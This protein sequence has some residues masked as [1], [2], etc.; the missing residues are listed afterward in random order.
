[1]A[2][3]A[4]NYSIRFLCIRQFQNRITDSVYTVIKQKIEDAG[5]QDEFDIGV[6]SIRHKTTGSDF[7]FYGMARNISDIK[8][9]E[10][11]DICW[12]EEGEALTEKQWTTIDPTI[13]KD[14]AEVWLLWNP[15]FITDFVQ[16]K[17]PELLGDDCIIRHINYDENPFLSD[18]ARKKANRLKIVD[19]DAYNHIYLGEPLTDEDSVIIKRSWINAAI[20]AHKKWDEGNAGDKRVGFDVAD[21]GDDLCATVYSYGSI[22]LW[23]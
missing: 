12:I 15:G 14:N 18:T 3:L 1:A 17:L 21:S 11:V 19:E 20:D 7:L 9:T 4:R 23:C 16:S 2:Y 6:S 8:G 10:G 22:A 5:W 13:R